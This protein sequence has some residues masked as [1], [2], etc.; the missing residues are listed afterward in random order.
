[1]H[2][3]FLEKNDI[4]A[5]LCTIFALFECL[6]FFTYVQHKVV[7]NCLPADP[8]SVC[9]EPDSLSHSG[10]GDLAE[11]TQFS[12]WV[13]FYEIY[14]EFLYDL[15]DASP[16]LQPKKRVTLRLSDDKHGNPYVKGKANLQN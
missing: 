13:S 7:F 14:N 11:G 5:F 4:V 16:S 12:I 9:L 6:Y 2:K 1:M 10:G 3:I 15:L 8:D